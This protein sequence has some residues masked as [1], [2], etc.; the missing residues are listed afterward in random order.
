MVKSRDRHGRGLRGRLAW[1]NPYT[2]AAVSVKT[3]PDRRSFFAHC[4]SDALA[5]ITRTCPRALG[6]VDVGIEDVPTIATSW[7]PSRVPL[8]A[9]LSPTVEVNGQIVLFRRP[10]ERRAATRKGLRIL[11]Y[12]TIVEQLASITGISVDEIDPEGHREADPDWD[13]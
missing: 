12:R 1:P 11:V 7:D 6:S 13:D 4:V 5:Q 10:L 9:A 8:A 2:G 3:R